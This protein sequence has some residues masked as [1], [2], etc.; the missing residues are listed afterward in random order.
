[1]SLNIRIAAVLMAWLY[2]TYLYGWN[3]LPKTTEEACFDLIFFMLFLDLA[4]Q[5]IDKQ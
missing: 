3:W 1:M 4:A 5:K 2:M